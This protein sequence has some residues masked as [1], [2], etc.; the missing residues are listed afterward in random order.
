MTTT[1]KHERARLLLRLLG[2]SVPGEPLTLESV[3]RTGGR[4]GPPTPAAGSKTI[5]STRSVLRLTAKPSFRSGCGTPS[6][7][8]RP[9]PPC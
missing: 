9:P 8:R 7:T 1:N 4:W 5:Q 2:G 3:E 6:W